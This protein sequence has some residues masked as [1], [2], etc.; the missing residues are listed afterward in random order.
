MGAEMLAR[1]DPGLLALEPAD[2]HLL[3]P[4]ALSERTEAG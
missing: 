1:P 4:V 3:L 2:I